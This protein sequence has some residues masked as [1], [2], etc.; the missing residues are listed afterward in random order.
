MTTIA[1][2]TWIDLAQFVLTA[3]IGAWFYLERKRDKTDELIA[4]LRTDL[5]GRIDDHHDRIARLETTSNTAPSHQDMARI[6]Q[7]IDEVSG[8]MKRLEGESG[9]QTRIL[10]LVYESLVS[11]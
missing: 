10:N 1:L 3:V 7:R 6:H 4:A 2:N 5:D 11:K 8:A 9:A